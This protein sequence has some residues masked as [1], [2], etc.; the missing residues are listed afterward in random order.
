MED[1]LEFYPIGNTV[2]VDVA[3]LLYSGD[4]HYYETVVSQDR[5]IYGIAKATIP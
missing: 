2:A 3:D 1:N 5:Q 4:K